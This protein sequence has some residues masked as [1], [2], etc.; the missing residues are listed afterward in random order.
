M[1][2]IDNDVKIEI[3]ADEERLFMSQVICEEVDLFYIDCY[4]REMFNK[5]SLES[6]M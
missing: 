3:I 1:E 2:N 5:E 6:Q 4:L